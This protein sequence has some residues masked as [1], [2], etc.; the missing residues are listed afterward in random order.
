MQIRQ[1][2]KIDVFHYCDSFVLTAREK[3]KTSHNN[4]VQTYLIFQKYVS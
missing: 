4:C 1:D 2:R 3:V